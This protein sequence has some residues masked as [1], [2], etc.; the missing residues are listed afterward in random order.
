MLEEGLLSED[1]VAG[2]RRLYDHLVGHMA[3]GAYVFRRVRQFLL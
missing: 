3:A 1:V 2:A